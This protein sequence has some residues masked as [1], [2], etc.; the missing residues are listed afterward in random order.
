MNATLSNPPL[1]DRVGTCCDALD[2][3]RVFRCRSFIGDRRV[4]ALWNDSVITF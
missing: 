4:T 1:F 2:Y 3:E